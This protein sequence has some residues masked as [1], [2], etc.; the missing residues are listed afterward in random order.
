MHAD[1]LAG[2]TAQTLKKYG[3]SHAKSQQVLRILEHFISKKCDWRCHC[4]AKNT[5]YCAI[6]Q[7]LQHLRFESSKGSLC[8]T[9]T[10]SRRRTSCC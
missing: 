5:H 3:A 2:R 8:G 9:Q 1:L 10:Y 4:I 6:S 7:V